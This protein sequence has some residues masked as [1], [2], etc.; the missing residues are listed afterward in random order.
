MQAVLQGVRSSSCTIAT[1]RVQFVTATTIFQQLNQQ[2]NLFSSTPEHTELNTTKRNIRKSGKDL[3]E[4]A[5]Q[6]LEK[7]LTLE[8]GHI[9]W[10]V[11]S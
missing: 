5:E 11:K 2:I 10:P 1:G 4:K 9:T 7:V 6:V 8:Q 3:G